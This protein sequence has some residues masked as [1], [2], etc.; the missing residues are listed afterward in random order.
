MSTV[1]PETASAAIRRPSPFGP[2][3]PARRNGLLPPRAPEPP[4][5]KIPD[6]VAKKGG[7]SRTIVSR[8][9]GN[10]RTERLSQLELFLGGSFTR[11][12]GEAELTATLQASAVYSTAHKGSFDSGSTPF[13]DLYAVGLQ[14]RL[15]FGIPI[16]PE[17]M[18]AITNGI[19]DAV[20]RTNHAPPRD[21]LQSVDDGLTKMQEEKRREQRE[22]YQRCLSSNRNTLC[23]EPK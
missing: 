15:A 2:L 6:V 12:L 17:G 13:P 1:G 23:V 18:G 10:G 21:K 22:A 8:D 4:E 9:F 16:G 11:F 14:V 7:V 19:V 20:D 3:R 5:Y